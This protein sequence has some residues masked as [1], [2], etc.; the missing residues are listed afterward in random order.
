M[1]YVFLILSTVCRGKYDL[2]LAIESTDAIGK[3][4]FSKIKDFAKQLVEAFTI[5]QSKTHVSLITYGTTATGNLWFNSLS[6]RSLNGKGIRSAIDG[7]EF[8]REGNT[9]STSEA[10]QLALDNVFTESGGSRENANKV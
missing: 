7:L 4:G 10:L 3:D 5:S 8:V 9:A 2:A 6:G 1:N